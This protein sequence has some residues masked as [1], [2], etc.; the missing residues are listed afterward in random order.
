M[1]QVGL[2]LISTVRPA[3]QAPGGLKPSR[4][5]RRGSTGAA[6]RELQRALVALGWLDA[7]ALMDGGGVFGPKTE[8]ALKQF[9]WH[10]R[11][12]ATGKAGQL[13]WRR[14]RKAAALRG[15]R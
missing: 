1:M 14:L 15:A 5:L 7:E 3:P 10:Q 13:T 12:P 2:S 8:S 4:F 9:Q 6:V 11:L